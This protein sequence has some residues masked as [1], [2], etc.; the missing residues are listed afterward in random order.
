MSEDQRIAWVRDKV[1]TA[2]GT[3]PTQFAD[4]GSVDQ[5][6]SVADLQALF[7]GDTLGGC[8][9]Y[10]LV[11]LKEVE[12]EEEILVPAEPAEP[13][14]KSGASIAPSVKGDAVPE[15][16]IPTAEEPL[17][18]APGTAPA[19]DVAS[20]ADTE[21]A[22][23]SRQP[24]APRMRKEIIKVKKIVEN[25]TLHM[26]VSTIPV[27]AAGT[28]A[29]YFLKLRAE[30]VPR[31]ETAADAQAS[32]PAH[33]EWEFLNRH[34]LLLLE[35]VISQLYLPLLAAPTESSAADAQ[36]RGESGAETVMSEEFLVAL[37][38]FDNHLRRTIQ[39]VEGDVKLRMPTVPP[40]TIANIDKCLADPDTLKQL[41][42][43]LDSW[44]QT[45]ASVVEQM[46]RKVPAGPGPLAE[47]ECWIERSS[48]LTALSEQLDL[49][50]VVDTLAVLTRAKVAG[51]SA[52][53][54]HRAELATCH[55]E[56][57][58][59]VKFLST[60][61]RHF[62]SIALCP[63]F[64]QATESLPSLLNAV[65]MVW[66]ISRHY[67]TDQRVVPLMERIAWL[68]VDKVNRRINI[69][70]IFRQPP[71]TIIAVCAEAQAML[72]AWETSYLEVR[73]KIEMSDRDERWE[74]D[75]TRLF[76]STNYMAG[77]LQD[78]HDIAQV[79]QEFYNIFGDELK[80]VTG[81][82]QVIDDVIVRV[83]GLLDPLEHVDFDP[84]E[85]RNSASWTKVMAGFR[86][87]V[88]RI[89][90]E[91]RFFI[92]ASFRSLRS[93]QGAFD[94]L[95]NFQHIKTR[96]TITTQL[97]LK[98]DDVLDKFSQEMDTVQRLFNEQRDA[99][100]SGRNLP[101]TARAI[102]WAHALFL[103]MKATILRFQSKPDLLKT[104]RGTAVSQKY[105]A[106]GR[107]I[108]AY[109]QERHAEWKT[110]AL[111][112]LPELLKQSIL[113]R[114]ESSGASE[115]EGLDSKSRFKVNYAIE[116]K[117]IIAEAKHLDGLEME[118]PEIVVNVTLQEERHLTYVD[119]LTKMLDRVHAV[120][121][122]LDEATE[123]LLRN[124]LRDLSLVLMPGLKRLNWSSLG[125]LDYVARCNQALET[126]S[127]AVG[128][129]NKTAADINAILQSFESAM[130]WSQYVLTDA[131]DTRELAAVPTAVPDLK[132]Y[133]DSIERL[134]AS[135]VD[136]LSRKYQSI[137]PL[138]TKVGVNLIGAG[139]TK[140]PLMQGYFAHWERRI[141]A[142]LTHMVMNNL[143]NL[144]RVMKAVSV[145]IFRVDVC[146]SA[147]D[148][149]LSPSFGEVYQLLSRMFHNMLDS[150]KSFPRWMNG[151]CDLTPPLFVEGEDEPIIFS[152]YDDISQ[153]PQLAAAV[154][155]LDA[156]IQA[157]FQRI[158]KFLQRW[159]R[160]RP[161]WKLD[162]T[163]TVQKFAS[164]S[165]TCAQFDEKL[166]FYARLADE[167]SSNAALKDIAFVRLQLTPLIDVVKTS[168]LSWVISL[169]ASLRE[170]IQA[171]ATQFTET[172]AKWRADLQRT[173]DDLD[174]LKFILRTIADIRDYNMT[175]ELQYFDLLE[176]FR[177]LRMYP[178]AE[179]LE[180]EQAAVQGLPGQWAAL[181]QDATDVDDKLVVVKR[182]F[183]KTTSKQIDEFH[184]QTNE[185][186][187][188][189]EKEGP[190]TVG[191]NLD[192]GLALMK[193]FKDE[194][195]T[196]EA[197][198]SQLTEAQQLFGL[199][200]TSYGGMSAVATSLSQLDLVYTLYEQQRTAR[201]NWAQTLWSN[202]NVSVLQEGMAEFTGRLRKFPKEVKELPVCKAVEA[203]L[204]EFKDSI[205]LFTDLKN[206]AL[207]DRHWKQLMEVTG[208]TFDMNPTTFTLAKLFEMQLHRF[209][210]KI[211]DI[212]TCAMKELSIEKGLTEVKDTWR[213][214]E[215]TVAKYTQG[216]VDKGF[217]LG[218][219]EEI[220]LL[221]DDNTMSLQSMTASRFVGPFIEQVRLWEKRLSS[222]AEVIDVWI[223][224]QRKWQYLE[225]IF[226]AG[227]IRQQLPNE[228][229]KFEGI[230]KAFKKLMQETAQKK[231][232]LDTCIVEGRYQMLQ[233]VQTDLDGCQKS[234]NDYLD[235]KRNAFPRFFFIS[236]DELLS[237]LGSHEC[238]CVQEHMIKM[239][240]NIAALHFGS[241]SSKNVAGAMVSAEGEEMVLRQAI[242]AEGRVEDWMTDVL[243]EMRRT[244]KLVTKEAVF[245]YM[246]S[247]SRTDW[248]AAS[249]GMV[250]LAGSQVWWTW[251]VEDVFSRV[252]QGD[253]KAM[254]VYS[255]KLHG[256]IDEMVVKVRMD[257]SSNER[258]KL[259][260][261]LIVDVHARDIVDRFVRD[262]ILDAREFEWESQL[263]F[264]FDKSTDDIVI[265]QC[266]GSFGY[267]YEYMGLNGRLVIT[268]L[269][270]RIYLTMTQALSMRL[271]GAPAG[272][273]GTGKTET[274][275][276]LAKA[277]AKQC[278]VFNCSDGLDFKAL[279]KFFKGLAS[280]GAWSCF[281]EFN[282][283]DV[284]VL[285]VISSQLKTLQHGLIMGLKNLQFEGSEISLDSRV[286]VFIT[287]N[288]GYA[289]R[290]EL[291]E[292]VKAL[293]RPVV[294]IVPDL[295][296]ICEIMLFSEGFL[297]A[298]VL[299]K[300]MTVLYKLSREQLSK[301]HHYDFGMRALKA[302]LVMAGE[303]KRGSPDLA[304]DVV[305][306][307]ALR[308]MNLPKFVFEDVPLFLGLI[309]DL[310]P[311]LDC[312]RV[313]YENFN[314]AVEQVL[315]D[316]KYIVLPH[317]VD[318]VVQLYETM[319]TRHTSMVVGGTGG[320]KS[321]VLNTLAQAQTRLGLPTKLHVL[322]SK[323]INISELYG[324]LDPVTRDWTDG[325]LSKTFR[326][327]CRPTDKQ[328]RRYIVFDSDVDALWV[329]NMNSVMDD[330]KILT[331]PNGE[332]IRLAKHCSLLIEVSDL[333]YASPATVSRAGMVYVD[334]KNL[335]F[336]PYWNRW[337]LARERPEQQEIFS[338]L[339]NKY[340]P[341][342]VQRILEGVEDGNMVERLKTIVPRTNLN[343]VT[344][345][346]SMLDSLLPVGRDIVDAPVLEAIFLCA[347]SWSL[348]ACLLET[349]RVVFDK[350]LRR[351]SGLPGA[352]V[353][354][355]GSLPTAQPT[356]FDY[357]F[358]VAANKWVAWTDVVPE[359][360]HNFSAAFHEILVPT[361]DTVRTAWLLQRMTS[362]ERPV[363]LV[364]DT[365]TSKTATI[366]NFLAGM[367]RDKTL[368]LNMNFSSRT[369]SLDVQ[370]SLEASVEK[371]TKDTF[372]PPPGRRL[373]VFIDDMNMPQVDAYGTQQAIALLKLLLERG[374][375]YDRGKDLIWKFLRDLGYIAA[376]GKPGGGRNN[377]DPRFLSLFSCFNVTFPS[378][379]S[380]QKIYSSILSGHL[381]G[382][383]ADVQALSVPL[384]QA[385]MALYNDIILSLPPTPSKFHYIFNLRDLSRVYEGLCLTTTDRFSTPA[386]L[387]RVW[388]N[389]C[390]RVFHDRLINETDKKQVQGLIE[391]L[392]SKSWPAAREPA[393]AE[394]I[395]FGDFRNALEAEK[396][397]LYEDFVDYAGARKVFEEI[398]QDYNE[399]N[400]KMTLVLFEDALEHLFRIHRILRMDRGHALLVGVGGSGKQSLARLAAWTAR[401]SVFE[402]TISR[403]YDE[404]M[405]REDLKKLYTLVGLECKKVMFLFTDAHVAEEGFLEL[406]NNI[407]TSGMVPALYADD[408]KESIITQV[409]D[410][411]QKRGI[412][413]SKENCWQFFIGRACDNLHV[414]LA[415]SPV[416][417]TLRTRCRNFPGLVNNTVIDWFMPWPV[418]A[419]TAVSSAF[420]GTGEDA[421]PLAAMI[422]D[423]VR[424]AVVEHVVHVHQSVTKY[425]VR[426]QEQLRRVNYVTPKN[427]LDFISQYL[428][429][430]SEKDKLTQQQCE[431]LEA[432]LTKITEAAGQLQELNA[433]L[434]V[435]KVTLAEKTAA[436]A[437]LL[438]EIST[439]TAEVQ[440]KQKQ[441]EA[442]ATEIAEQ[443]V[444]ISKEKKEA[445]DAL[446]TALPALEEAKLALK[447]L[448]KAD[449]TEIRSFAKP[450]PQVQT[451][452]ECIVLMMNGQ[453]ISW[454]AAKGLMTD[455]NFLSQLLTMDVDAIKE[456][457]A[458]AIN[459]KLKKLNT[460]YEKFREISIAGAGLFKFVNAVMGYC[461]VAK[462][463]KPKRERV[464]QLEKN[465]Y[466]AK[467]ELERI[468]KE[469]AALEG[470]LKQLGQRYE[471]SMNEKRKLSEEAELM[472]RR[473]IAADKLI[474]GLGSERDRWN[475]DL[476]RLKERRVKLVGDC[477]LG[478]AFLSYLGAF[479]Y[480]FRREMLQ[481][482]WL[483]DLQKRT[484]PVSEPFDLA[485]LLT[486]EVEISKWTSEGLPPD[487]LSIQNGMLT[488]RA[489]NFPLC[490][491][492]Q[493]QALQWILKRE[494]SHSLKVHTFND[495]DFLKQLEL[496]IKFGFP[497]LFRD[498]DE[499][500]DPV[501]DN[502]LE[503]NI[504]GQGNRRYVV[505]GDK[506][507]DY[508]PNF[509]LY[510]NTKLSNPKYSPSVFGKA[511][512]INYSVT[513]SGLED[514][515]LSVLVGFERR[516]LEEQ[517]EALIQ[518]TS[519]N[520]GLL[521][522][523]E[524]TLLRELAA[525][526]GN[527][528]DNVELV[529]TLENTKSKA[530]E[531]QE[532]L[533]LAER[534]AR[535]INDI[536]DGY[537]PA[538][539]R[540]AVLFFV[541]SE[542][543]AINS[544][545]QY[546]LTAYLEVFDQ[547]LRRSL[548]DSYLAKRLQNIIDTLTI[549]V[550]TYATT[551]LFERHKLLFSFQMAVRLLESNNAL[552]RIELD[553]FT[554]GNVS[555]EA[556]TR[557]KPHAWLAEQGWRDIVRL[558]AVVPEPFAKL[559]EDVEKNGSVWKEWF[560][561]EAPESVALPCGYDAKVSPFQRL[562]ILRCFRVDRVYRAVVA[563]VT[564]ALGE[565]FVQ[566]PVVR[567]ETVHE[568]SSPN[569]PIVFIL[570][571]GSDPAGDLTKLAEKSGFSG[572]RLKFLAMGQ[573]QGKLALQLLETAAQRGQW[574]MLQNCHL[575]VRWLKDLEKAL[576]RIT[577]PHPE[578]R[579]WLTTQPTPDFPIGILQRSLKVVSEP[580]NGLKLN[581]RATFS[582]IP[583]NALAE[584]ECAHPA[585]R[586]LVFTLAFFHAVVQERRKYGK[587]GWNI[588]YDFNENDFRVCMS[589]LQ[590]YLVKAHQN[591]DEKL[592]WASLKYLIGEVMYGG[593][594]IDNFD[595]RVLVTYM[596]EYMGDFLFDAFQ[597]FHFYESSEA[598]YRVPAD[599]SSRD[600]FVS[601]I[602]SLPLAN[603]PDVFGLHPNAEIGY[604][605]DTVQEMWGL[606]VE[607]QPQ[608][609]GSSAG[610][611]RED[612]IAEVANGMKAKIPAPFDID[613]VRTQFG[614]EP[615]PTQVVLMQE[616]ERWNNLVVYMQA[617]LAELLRALS[618]EVGMSNQLDEIARALFN[619]QLPPQW[620]R[621]APDTLK[622]LGNWMV[623]F[624]RRYRQY[625]DWIK[626]GDPI[627]MWLSGLH[628]PESYLT[629]LVQTTC[630]KHGWPLDRSTLYSAVTQYTEPA[631]IEERPASGCYVTGLYLEGASWDIK[632]NAL[633]PPL[634][635]QLQQ[636]LPILQI[637]PVETAKLKLHGTYRTPVYTTSARRN[638][639]GIGLVF[640]AD[641]ASHEHPS[642]WTLMGVC[643]TLNSS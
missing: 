366:T 486:N 96:E 368:V 420:L 569:S 533:S 322:N 358:D 220:T 323:A 455:P 423:A 66:I 85:R 340:I 374:G 356:L 487:E 500:I 44:A 614:N 578:F 319:L 639:M 277:V 400:L 127:S 558:A 133:C 159:R 451:V 98:Y 302:V 226:L 54:Y 364:G 142:S 424:E 68:L 407:L 71:S 93:A 600:A 320:G 416:G 461:S 611:S 536:R 555:L 321:V 7:D 262:S 115:G 79:M 225:G 227:D 165:P 337:C 168:A 46:Q 156:S 160:Y 456:K 106:I 271:G 316:G 117:Q 637:I 338:N 401:Y 233:Q 35:R 155:A 414:V 131:D 398:L 114:D 208:T 344:Q 376:M 204:N 389:E 341:A 211:G 417:E 88:G 330:N 177:T 257:L 613:R 143:N 629:A 453:D 586:P 595:R 210:E 84:T 640:E 69:R 378:P 245:R 403:G 468:Q 161:L 331:L 254:K 473:L 212:T 109:E 466:L 135:C 91:A 192:A 346:C 508:D 575:L 67:N 136:R 494:A 610:G 618:G 290:T 283:I 361:T 179:Y 426:F 187:A 548:P 9:F 408:E 26:S 102:R 597:P 441:A 11:D 393:M 78:L 276:D 449:V 530:G 485:L 73:Q 445:E 128:N 41:E 574:L 469:C 219:T 620:R 146:L 244:N 129:I 584:A 355:P 372:G 539:K 457:N 267:G 153:D 110:R 92:D 186:Q 392:I 207:R 608:T 193:K 458:K 25:K 176:R 287:M 557:P 275:K 70:T 282:R 462:E 525:S 582:K 483:K 266:S 33:V 304:E 279:G 502:V 206:E 55:L 167:I 162:R 118:I 553:F 296:Q 474:S 540:G 134:R 15:I 298:S 189:F 265:R 260:T 409:R 604:F 229:R 123:R 561:L 616:L 185:F 243:A 598:D 418:Q 157:A 72:R 602:E 75:R 112:V 534:T 132:E 113:V 478:S 145:P 58:D 527:M 248:I 596:D 568:S 163:I 435:Q 1:C 552:P 446:A 297:L 593:R 397:R 488:T 546:S 51:L 439:N 399:H 292:S 130:L 62:K 570:S 205:P 103:R 437:K 178:A 311:G 272:P 550:Y 383:G 605:T 325:L 270:D 34:A 291:P 612:F 348:G 379:Q 390:L 22:A 498:V 147:P 567:F 463:I 158:N 345:L 394:P 336:E 432:G 411:V 491:D 126:F 638:A 375:L 318:K 125:I 65:R 509:R 556:V 396:P 495:P 87:Q 554:K 579:L 194:L 391:K 326:E 535:Q 59:N 563:F 576:E 422:P 544:M 479:T 154:A 460:P 173:P 444:Q 295:E 183:T 199:P 415:M 519:V 23:A 636:E 47:I 166:Q 513:L 182:R 190:A 520:R 395:L 236:D 493:Q 489:K 197:A 32:M 240:D 255:K 524:D 360:K 307:R 359:Y 116:F 632:R 198:R 120:L 5:D 362:I 81:N 352:A 317:Q 601:Y 324:V 472:Q 543:A 201:E 269:T 4:L 150:L 624:E 39:Q 293:F 427:Y 224:V 447:D 119:S 504:I 164:K 301:Q 421:N 29:A 191:A 353:A 14:P 551:G 284:S 643:L 222:V 481:E 467:R 641:L 258:K 617:S 50:L 571:A 21:A 347:V 107:S 503:K 404:T 471:D 590:T 538:A 36:A 541:L 238:T 299:A 385:T 17:E 562:C 239:F 531:V 406:I 589:I 10:C 104:D 350:Y 31:C 242:T 606:L 184:T 514:Q 38:K 484:V 592:P 2:L 230:D 231:N 251:E 140:D 607:L 313:R 642:H 188:V 314:A 497:F 412:F 250:A 387:V 619:G 77:F 100:P 547:S 216:E 209:S 303:L 587:I 138:L 309:R 175:A 195:K 573:G 8:I 232:V 43:A 101:P 99:P 594:A 565:R 249:L 367:D 621:L 252:A 580:P 627:V 464:A 572:N 615:T 442:A 476:D 247:G 237:I 332:R 626:K 234:L 477:L 111:A 241:G 221:L 510:L 294:V 635:K 108:R 405:L 343:M 342:C 559:P 599:T 380:L 37:R 308:D 633:A 526:T 264:Y 83:R 278:V 268:P 139:A 354:G 515:L 506:E 339:Y 523:L 235:A 521:K 180:T 196:L 549:N 174:S 202:L 459:E 499:Y 213:V 496:A 560:D 425:S 86:E 434:E 288:P 625:D 433:K 369:R 63:T 517:R 365:G 564:Q 609:A 16:A 516:E 172:M 280:S 246:E 144:I 285:S 149:V 170:A 402:I 60:L 169:G 566:P 40:A 335:G 440:S 329:E 410:E 20:Q 76:D 315:A 300:K 152:F 349:E 256:Q 373:L 42:G 27:A 475:K 274:V 281:D 465:F 386:A 628:I 305:L 89:E 105:L 82:P 518:E 90:G 419:L 328:E 56:A 148:V 480:E 215:F 74:F 381:A 24:S 95:Q 492:P 436:C 18:S 454:K 630:R 370:R 30:P 623:H 253:K 490:I 413:P 122:S 124:Y 388:R 333:Q 310:F 429:L 507:V 53:T 631:A 45:I 61:E 228:A 263:R 57:K 217:V 214:T 151:T 28:N 443:S 577:H 94:M 581:L 384:T 97:A 634:P 583:E 512:I 218:S 382:F 121:S 431:R 511:K 591:N 438:D 171:R 64:A 289:G 622:S 363:L 3:T 259:N 200:A 334:P 306:M 430:L 371:R 181:C 273:A 48:T 312:P 450:P 529:Q 13:R 49:P 470:E 137:G 585:F 377:V 12:V 80:S 6:S 448:D 141:F 52:F 428:S 452:C 327:C 203:S 223:V 501:I 505:L 522:D 19:D 286:G 482:D 542:M 357:S 351:L 537:R 261:M 545:Y 588:S 532:K 603:G 528:L